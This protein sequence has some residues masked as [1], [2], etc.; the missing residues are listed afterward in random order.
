MAKIR[1]AK[2]KAALRKAQLASARKRRG[3]GKAKRSNPRRRRRAAIGAAAVVSA[4]LGSAYVYKNRERLVIKWEA[5][6]RAIVKRQRHSKATY[7]RKLT[8]A[9]KRE[10]RMTERRLHAQRSTL[11]VREYG[12]A[13]QF[14][15]MAAKGHKLGHLRTASL[16]PGKKGN[17]WEA[18]KKE[19]FHTHP[20]EQARYFRAYR[21]SVYSRAVARHNRMKGKKRAYGYDSGKRL[22]VNPKGKVKRAWW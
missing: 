1:T 6:R 21:K 16:R 7:G 13:R 9:E 18:M 19:S 11:K 20:D 12:S 15:Q 3:K 14:A 2:Q 17:L 5:E 8:K 22:L 10:V 4:G